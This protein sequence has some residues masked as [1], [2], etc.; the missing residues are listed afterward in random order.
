M[1]SSINLTYCSRASEFQFLVYM[2]TFMRKHEIASLFAIVRAGAKETS[3]AFYGRAYDAVVADPSLLDKLRCFHA[4]SLDIQQSQPPDP[5][6]PPPPLLPHAIPPVSSFPLDELPFANRAFSSNAQPDCCYDH[7]V[8]DFLTLPSEDVFKT[9]LKAFSDATGSAAMLQGLCGSCGT[10]QFLSDMHK[11]WFTT[12]GASDATLPVPNRDLL[13]PL[14]SI[15][16][17]H[18]SE[19]LRDGL[20]IHPPAIDPVT[21]A[22]HLC[23]Q[24]HRS[25]SRKKRPQHSLANGRW[26]GNLPDILSTLT[27]PESMLVSLTHCRA[28]LVKLRPKMSVGSDPSTLTDAL[29][30]NITSVDMPV[31]QI[32]DMLAGDFNNHLPHPPSLLAS[33]LQVAFLSFKHPPPNLRGFLRV[34]RA[35]VFRAL[36]WLKENNPEYSE[37]V[38]SRDRL[39]LLPVNGVPDSIIVRSSTNARMAST[40]VRENM[41]NWNTADYEDTFAPDDRSV[42][43]VEGF[44]DLTS[45][46]HEDSWGSFAG[47]TSNPALISDCLQDFSDVFT[48]TASFESVKNVDVCDNF[49]CKDLFLIH[50]FF[51]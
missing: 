24:C 28:W 43:T 41:S 48:C 2:R 39:R 3:H 5:S 21:G 1:V 29:R 33:L 49:L 23:L 20:L 6:P 36:L 16:T 27:L 11:N 10:K 34:R 45:F 15:P 4:S 7:I 18:I 13:I 46:S 51:G 32:V 12:G 26:V 30:G 19:D 40:A 14:S 44:E 22:F 25:L 8:N 31:D 47:F 50:F 37:V 9:R 17:R 42:E 35:V 38:I